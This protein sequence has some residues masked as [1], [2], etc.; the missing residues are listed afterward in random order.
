VVEKRKPVFPRA[1]R[2]EQ[3]ERPDY[4]G[5]DEVLGAGYGPVH[6]GFGGEMAD[7]IYG[8]CGKQAVHGRSV[9]YVG[10]LE[11][12]AAPETFGDLLQIGRVSGIGELVNVYDKPRKIGTGKKVSDE[13]RTD[14]SAPAGY[15]HAFHCRGPRF[16]PKLTARSKN[17]YEQAG[18]KPLCKACEVSSV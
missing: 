15:E 9:G 13:I 3:P 12:I 1:G 17:D 7:G 2:F 11:N 5:A 10:V 8:V 6:V 4:V 18:E 16:A 14:E